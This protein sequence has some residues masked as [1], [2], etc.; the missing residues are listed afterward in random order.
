MRILTTELVSWQ[1]ED[2][3]RNVK[4]S[5]TYSSWTL[6]GNKIVLLSS[7]NV[8]QMLYSVG[9]CECLQFLLCNFLLERYKISGTD[10]PNE[11]S[12]SG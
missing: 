3:A 6:V 10:L 4:T 9:S 11:F 2:F 7:R 8:G 5:G 1:A 12:C